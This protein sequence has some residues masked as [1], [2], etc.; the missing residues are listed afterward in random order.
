MAT[1]TTAAGARTSC[2]GWAGAAAQ[3]LGVKS[4]LS[5]TW[6]TA[7][8]AMREESRNDP[9]VTRIATPRWFLGQLAAQAEVMRR[10]AE[11]RLPLLV[12]AGDADPLADST[13][14]VE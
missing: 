9:W 10:A 5:D 13:A 12:L 6:M 14:A 4:G 7:D 1:A 3:W 8:L 2:A 11:F